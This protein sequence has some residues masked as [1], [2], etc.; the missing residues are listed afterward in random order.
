MT[1]QKFEEMFRLGYRTRVV[2]FLNTLEFSTPIDTGPYDNTGHIVTT[3]SYLGFLS[4]EKTHKSVRIYLKLK[5]LC[6]R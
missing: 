3:H 2:N 4:S 1:S 6:C 5:Y